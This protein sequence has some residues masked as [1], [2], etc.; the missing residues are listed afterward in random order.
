M[1]NHNQRDKQVIEEKLTTTKKTINKLQLINVCLISVFVFALIF[2]LIQ[3]VVNYCNDHE[4]LSKTVCDQQLTGY[5]INAT[6]ALLIVSFALIVIIFPSQ[7][8]LLTLLST[9]GLILIGRLTYRQLSRSILH[10][11]INLIALISQ[12][13]LT[14]AIYLKVKS[15]DKYTELNHLLQLDQ[16]RTI[17]NNYIPLNT[18]V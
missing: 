13:V 17:Q 10:E 8:K 11:N 1:S 18:R 16:D 9:T 3:F 14:L 15:F 6:I 2:A 5:V 7:F 12:F 4:H